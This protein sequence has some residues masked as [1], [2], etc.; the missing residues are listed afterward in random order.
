MQA[1][2]L[3]SEPNKWVV[4]CSYTYLQ[5]SGRMH[6]VAVVDARNVVKNE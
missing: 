3:R 2:F 4:D 6:W 1:G 5:T